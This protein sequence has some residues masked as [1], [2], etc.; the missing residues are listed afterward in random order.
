MTR[1]FAMPV[2]IAALLTLAACS[3]GSSSSAGG[4]AGTDTG[5][6]DLVVSASLQPETFSSDAFASDTDGDG[7][8]DQLVS[9]DNATLAITI[10]DP[11]GNF[12]RTFQQVDFNEFR[13]R[14]IKGNAAAPTLGPRRVAGSLSITL[15]DSSGSGSI[16]IPLVDNVT[17]R[18]FRE[19]ASGSTI[20][21]YTVEVRAI[22][23]DIATG[24]RI[25][26][27]TSATIEI[28]EFVE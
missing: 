2:A 5:G 24:S 26:V 19:R 27:V 12:S 25:V 23:R 9:T 14:F 17:K 1:L 6:T 13:I 18:E 22:G 11:Q 7:E 21:N 4:G 10:T 28:G 3:S 20:F 15:S 16:T 8:V